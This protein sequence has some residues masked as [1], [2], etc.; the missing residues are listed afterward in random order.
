MN[1]ESEVEVKATEN[2]NEDVEVGETETVAKPP[3][4][5]T[6]EAKRARLK[7]QLK[8]VEQQLG[9]EETTETPV[10][11]KSFTLGYAEKAYLN[12]N[13]IKGKD[14]YALVQDMVANTGKEIEDLI[15]NKYFQSELKDLR[16]TRESKLASDALSGTNRNGNSARDSV[17]YWI[18]KGELPPAYM[19]QLRRDVVNAQIKKEKSGSPFSSNPVVG[20]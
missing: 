11:R 10:E 13:G 9:I 3:I 15:D 20:K 2:L 6:A 12:A 19:V 17:D 14:E 5:E 1:N 7:R 18:G 4:V 16:N 8:K